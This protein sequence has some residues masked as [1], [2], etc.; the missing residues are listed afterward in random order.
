[1]IVITS[2]KINKINNYYIR[3]PCVHEHVMIG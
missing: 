3:N 2:E 1:M